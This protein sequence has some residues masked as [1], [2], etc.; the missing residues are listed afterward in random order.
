L[1]FKRQLALT[2]KNIAHLKGTITVGLIFFLLIFTI[3]LILGVLYQLFIFLGWQFPTVEKLWILGISII[4]A[5]ALFVLLFLLITLYQ[6][7]LYRLDIVRGKKTQYDTDS[8]Q[9]IEKKSELYI[10]ISSPV[11]RK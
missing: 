3:G 7:I 9:I 8:Y 2:E 11:K 5:V 1:Y 6:T 10:K 4:K